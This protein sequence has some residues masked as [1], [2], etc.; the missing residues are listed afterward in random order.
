MLV[1]GRAIIYANALGFA[2]MGGYKHFTVTN[3]KVVKKQKTMRYKSH[4]ITQTQ[5]LAIVNLLSS[6]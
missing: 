5:M 1:Q 4:E 2:K 6:Q 3:T